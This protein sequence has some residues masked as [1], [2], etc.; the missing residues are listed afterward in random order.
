M[1]LENITNQ[2]YHLSFPTQ[3][4]LNSTFVRFQEHFESPK[5]R[6]KFFSLNEFKKWY[7]KSSEGGKRTGKFTYYQDWTGFNIPSHIL[8]PFYKGGFDPLSQK[9]KCL[10]ELF[11]DKKF[12]R[13][14]LI[15]TSEDT[16]EDALEH[17]IAHGLFYTN[18]EYKKEVLQ[19]LETD[20]DSEARQ[21]LIDYFSPRYHPDSFED[22]IHAYLLEKEGYWRTE[23]TS[24]EKFIPIQRKLKK[25]F[26]KYTQ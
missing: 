19:I 10:L 8:L 13:F 12:Q 4:E 2:I 14:Y 9:E 7:I 15:G 11:E 20:L 16:R 5:F 17:E 23:G 25:L 21:E 26:E 18:P 1:K 3:Y 22:E 6:G 24:V